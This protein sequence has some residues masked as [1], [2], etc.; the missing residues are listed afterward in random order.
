MSVIN[1][2]YQKACR[3]AG[4]TCTRLSEFL[5]QPTYVSVSLK[6][7]CCAFFYKILENVASANALQFEA[8]RR[9][10]RQSVFSR[11]YTTPCQD[12]SPLRLTSFWCLIVFTLRCDIDLWFCDLD[13]RPWT[14]IMYRLWPDET[15]Y[16]RPTKFES[17]RTI[18]GGVIV[19]WMFDPKFLGVT[20]WPWTCFTC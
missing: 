15:L 19:V 17:N 5:G 18:R 10:P 20:L 14:F 12:W 8:A 11:N 13:L 6:V 1:R 3:P 7:Y 9:T 2:A 4:N 16:Y